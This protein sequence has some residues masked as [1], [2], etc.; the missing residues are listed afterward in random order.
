MSY[1]SNIKENWIFKF[2][3]QNGANLFLAFQDYIDSSNN[4]YHGVI[5]NNP[6][7]RESIDLKKSTAKTSNISLD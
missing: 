6:S 2:F 4:F 7:I 3:N 1:S 5:T